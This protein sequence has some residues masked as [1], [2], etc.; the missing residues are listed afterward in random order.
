MESLSLCKHAE[1]ILDW[2]DNN[3]T[4]HENKV[5][6]LNK[7]LCIVNSNAFF[8]YLN[9]SLLSSLRGVWNFTLELSLNSELFLLIYTVLIHTTYNIEK[10]HQR[11]R[12]ESEYFCTQKFINA[13]GWMRI[14]MIKIL[15]NVPLYLE[16]L[17]MY[18]YT[19]ISHIYQRSQFN[20]LALH[21]LSA[22]LLK[23]Y[24]LINFIYSYIFWVLVSLLPFFP[25]YLFFL[26]FSCFKEIFRHQFDPW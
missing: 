20:Q 12:K 14:V 18:T 6:P 5:W 4:R 3:L 1:K 22:A 2:C 19:Y 21:L 7:H 9:L 10:D 23:W 13:A 15:F 17:H 26:Y 16:S 24:I 25:F 8:V 11:V